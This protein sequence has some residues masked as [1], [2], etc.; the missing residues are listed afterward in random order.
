MQPQAGPRQWG[1]RCQERAKEGLNRDSLHRPNQLLYWNRIEAG[2]QEKKTNKQLSIE[3]SY[4]RRPY[5]AQC[6]PRIA[7][8][9]AG[10]EGV[11]GG[12][13]KEHLNQVLD[14]K[15]DSYVMM[16]CVMLSLL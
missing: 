1:G 2:S 5:R 7:F 8:Q 9:V 10:G 15:L 3:T 11:P 12:V 16:C 13:T 6:T 4:F 14:F